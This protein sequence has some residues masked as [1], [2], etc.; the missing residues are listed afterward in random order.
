M[1]TRCNSPEQA[2]AAAQPLVR[3]AQA[4]AS[5][6]GIAFDILGYIRH[7]RGPDRPV[8]YLPSVKFA[9]NSGEEVRVYNRELQHA[10]VMLDDSASIDNAIGEELV[11]VRGEIFRIGSINMVEVI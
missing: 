9:D 7:M 5:F 11:S 10:L 1:S 4:V 2:H 6:G 3:P 8:I